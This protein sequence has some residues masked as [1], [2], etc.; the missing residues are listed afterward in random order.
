MQIFF[1]PY[2]IW[3]GTVCHVV[4][5][6]WSRYFSNEYRVFGSMVIY[7]FGCFLKVDLL[8]KNIKLMFFFLYFLYDFDVLR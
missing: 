4:I 1:Y 2:A 3:S 8:L 6:C 7:I 5:L